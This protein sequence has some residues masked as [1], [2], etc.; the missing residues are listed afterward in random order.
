MSANESEFQ[1]VTPEN[2]EAPRCDVER[3]PADRVTAVPRDDGLE[4]R[5][6]RDEEW[7][8]TDTPVISIYN[9]R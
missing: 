9:Y 2:I 5:S 3:N 8:K 7:I 4:L 6:A 1:F